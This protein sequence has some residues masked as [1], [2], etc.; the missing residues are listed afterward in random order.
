MEEYQDFSDDHD[1]AK[2]NADSACY[3]MLFAFDLSPI[4]RQIYNKTAPVNTTVQSTES[5]LDRRDQ[6]IWDDEVKIA[7]TI[8]KFVRFSFLL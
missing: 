7:S 5:N 6:L 4:S 3:S 1:D 2:F 8:L